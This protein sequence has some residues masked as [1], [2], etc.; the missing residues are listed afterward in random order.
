MSIEFE[1]ASRLAKLKSGI[2]RKT[3]ESYENLTEGVNALIAGYG[4][5]GTV[6]S[7]DVNFYDYDGTLVYS[8]TLDEVKAMTELPA[9]PVHEGLTAQRWNYSLDTLKKYTRAVDVGATYTTDDG[10]TRIYIRL[11]DGRTSLKFGYGLRGIGEL[12]V[13]WGDGSEPDVVQ[14]DDWGYIATKPAHEY[15]ASGDYVIRLYTDGSLSFRGDGPDELYTSEI[16]SDRNSLN[17]IKKVEMGANAGLGS[18]AF[19]RCRSL[20]SVAFSD[21]SGSYSWV[22]QEC[23]SLTGVVLPTGA[24]ELGLYAFFECFA[25]TK[26]VLA[27]DLSGMGYSAFSRCH[28]LPD[29]M[30]PDTVDEF[31]SRDFEECY[32]LSSIVL[33]D[34]VTSIRD[35]NFKACYTLSDVVIPDSVRKIERDAF[36]NC[37]SFRNIVIP[38]G[39]RSVEYNT[40]YYCTALSSVTFLGNITSVGSYAFYECCSL[41]YCDFTKCTAVPTLADKNAF[42]Y[43]PT[44][45]EIRVPMAL[46]D[47][48]KSATNWA[49]YASKIV[50][51]EV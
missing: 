37:K 47:E 41:K 14:G 18:G 51:V 39:V 27:E 43:T 46:V 6:R 29:I 16:F 23:E 49:T 15:E 45:L 8:Y 40:F 42:S 21:D 13:D 1:S 12:T 22:F 50:G 17:A 36:S 4:S 3:G 38:A 9:M 20:T 31:G 30:I 32:T 2:E 11:E 48:W 35:D 24:Y 34:G 25:L 19:A 26:V 10:T 7:E 33:P 28:S 44:D 5:G